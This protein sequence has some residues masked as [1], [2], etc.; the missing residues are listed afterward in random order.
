[1]ANY[2]SKAVRDGDDWL[3]TGQNV[4]VSGY[5]RPDWLYGPMVTDPEA[6]R[7]RNLGCFMIPYPS[8][9]LEVMEQNLL[10]G[11]EQH[12]IFLDNVR[13][14]GDHLIGGDHQGWQ[15]A[16][17]SL[18]QE[19]GGRG[20]AFPTDESVDNLVK[21]ARDTKQDGST[22]GKDPVVQQTTMQAYLE[23]HVSGIFAKRTFWMY[24][25]HMEIT[26]EG[27]ESSVYSREYTP[28]NAT[29]IRDVM[30]LYASWVYES[31]ESP[32]VGNRR[33]PSACGP[34]RT[35]PAGAPTSLRWSWLG[36]LASAAPKSGRLPLPPL[37][38]VTA[39][40]DPSR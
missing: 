1:M 37:R 29:R 32:L 4:F 19:H 18:E 31:Q 6:P 7:H 3:L 40:S 20:Q 5:G 26:Y 27:N 22:L 16:N 13:V 25:N 35:T 23:A 28:R 11:G 12:F 21:Y 36:G 15:V 8:Q 30:G 17:T 14:P 10:N 24:Q 2:Q 38:R 9:G 39:A 33:S 34:V